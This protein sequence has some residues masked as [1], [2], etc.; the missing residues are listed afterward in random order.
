MASLF[1]LVIWLKEAHFDVGHIGL[2]IYCF[3]TY[4]KNLEIKS[5]CVTFTGSLSDSTLSSVNAFEICSK[6]RRCRDTTFFFKERTTPS[7]DL[8]GRLILVASVV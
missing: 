8:I 3:S 4:L 5:A 1:V 6:G 2:E 7:S